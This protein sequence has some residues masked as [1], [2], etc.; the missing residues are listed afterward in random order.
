M[1]NISQFR[2]NLG[3]WAYHAA[4]QEFHLA[5]DEALRQAASITRDQC[6][7]PMQWDNTSNA[8][9]S[10][11]GVQTWL[12]INQDYI[13]G[14]NIAD[15]LDNPES[16]INFYRR[17][18][19]IRK[20]TPALITG[21][22]I[23]LHERAETYLAFLRS[24]PGQACLVILN[25]AQNTQILNFCQLATP[26]DRKALLL[27]SST[28]RKQPLEDLNKISVSPHEIYIAELQ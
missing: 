5:K 10:P 6:R 25:Y 4:I 23:P 8:G 26:G 11:A 7:S 3:V 24:T 14:V 27:F 9:F 21:D 19:A 18:L 20:R 13:K 15:Q 2:D 1:D 17:L 28:K 22:Y 12:P 16:L